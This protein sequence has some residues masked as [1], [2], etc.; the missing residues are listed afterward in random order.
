MFQDGITPLMF[1][2]SSGRNNFVSILMDG[3]AD[4]HAKDEE[5]CTALHFAAKNGHDDVCHNLLES[6]A[7]VSGKELQ[8]SSGCHK[9]NMII[10]LSC[11]HCIIKVPAHSCKLYFISSL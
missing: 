9:G 1:A 7:N 11:V 4:V 8:F 2:S 3:G 5:E 6:G 10:N